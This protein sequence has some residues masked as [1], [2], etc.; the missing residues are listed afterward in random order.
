MG[1]MCTSPYSHIGTY[2]QTLRLIV[3]VLVEAF[4]LQL[5]FKSQSFR[6]S[7]HATDNEYKFLVSSAKI[8]DEHPKIAVS[9]SVLCSIP[10]QACRYYARPVTS[11]LNFDWMI[12]PGLTSVF[13]LE[14]L[15]F[16]SI[17]CI[18]FGK[19]S[20]LVLEDRRWQVHRSADLISLA[21]FLIENW[22]INIRQ[23]WVLEFLC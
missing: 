22:N 12:Y 18:R 21:R 14:L 10:I 13:V 3:K 15:R 20:S 6:V 2:R 4:Q 11:A 9:D 19:N 1:T 16:Y 8:P 17:Q 7:K 23:L 5:H